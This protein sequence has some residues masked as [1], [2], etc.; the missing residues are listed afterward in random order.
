MKQYAVEYWGFATVLAES[1]EEARA[2][3]AKI[4]HEEMVDYEE[5]KTIDFMCCVEK[6]SPRDRVSDVIRW[7]R[8]RW[9]LAKRAIAERDE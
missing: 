4:K 3:F 1:E 8:R 5:I 7:I 2:K 6:R 9:N